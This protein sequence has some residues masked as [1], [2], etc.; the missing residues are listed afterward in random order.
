MIDYK[1]LQAIFAT[2]AAKHVVASPDHNGQWQG[3]AKYGPA[4]NYEVRFTVPGDFM[5]RGYVND[6]AGNCYTAYL[7]AK[8]SS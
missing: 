6:I 8:E 4:L 2:H 1:Q 5:N 3:V 7:E